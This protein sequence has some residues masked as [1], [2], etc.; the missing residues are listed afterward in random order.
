MVPL[1][2]VVTHASGVHDP[3][4]IL[5]P[6]G[7]LIPAFS[8]QASYCD[9]V[10]QKRMPPNVLDGVN[11][12]PRSLLIDKEMAELKKEMDD[13]IEAMVAERSRADGH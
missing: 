2:C 8:E 10:L 5:M 1:F 3:F 12:H 13:F 4:C 11:G 7:S 9:D 6:T